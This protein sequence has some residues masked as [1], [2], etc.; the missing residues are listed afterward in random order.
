MDSAQITAAEAL[1]RDIYGDGFLTGTRLE[2]ARDLVH[3][4][5][6]EP[7][8]LS[9]RWF[10]D[11]EGSRLFQQIM[12]LPEYYPTVRETEILRRNADRIAAI[13]G[14]EPLS[15][16]ELGAGDGRKTTILLRAFSHRDTCYRPIDCSRSA[17]ET[18]RDNVSAS[19]PGQK[20]QVICD[21]NDRGLAELAKR[22]GDERVF[23]LFLGSS[24]GNLRRAEV[25]AFLSRLQAYLR[26]DDVVMIGFD[27][28]K[29]IS[30]L[31]R[32]YADSEGVTRAF[33]LN[34]LMRINRE[35][36]ADFACSLFAHE[37]I[38]NPR[39]RAME[40][41]LF[42]RREQW[43]NV[44]AIGRSFQLRKWEGI[45]TE[46]SLKFDREEIDVLAKES[47]FEPITQFEDRNGDFVDA[48][49]R[50]S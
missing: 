14:K 5:S 36:K 18:L 19:I 46:T 24:I 21:D 11:A 9:S 48:V 23:L 28:L 34:L 17:L 43:V 29:D 49:W 37:A 1:Q 4:F 2:L 20:I 42:S 22:R 50:V 7:K 25:P 8:A 26:K 33:N 41:W 15:I 13:F 30:R 16:V 45:H 47:G 3:G 31:V 38:W 12:D 27:L 35:L 39:E 44:N 10:Y 40:S 6:R 32:A